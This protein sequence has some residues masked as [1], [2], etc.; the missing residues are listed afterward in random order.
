MLKES[1]CLSRQSRQRKEVA[2]K[3]SYFATYT[4]MC[5]SRKLKMAVA[6]N[7]NVSIHRQA[8]KEGK[9]QHKDA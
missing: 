8:K 3:L 1:I 9:R 7:P 6:Y 4:L 2:K 5:S